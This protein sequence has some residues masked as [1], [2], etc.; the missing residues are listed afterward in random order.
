LVYL[1]DSEGIS[2]ILMGLIKI[3]INLKVTY[4]GKE[5]NTKGIFSS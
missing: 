2:N 3:I 1:Y 5:I 4:K